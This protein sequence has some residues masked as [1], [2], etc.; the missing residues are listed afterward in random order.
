MPK[1]KKNPKAQDLNAKGMSKPPGSQR[2]RT[3]ASRL[4][5]S[6]LILQIRVCKGLFADTTSG[7]NFLY[8]T[9]YAYKLCKI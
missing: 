8:C 6:N 1:I 7:I 2:K 3:G 5:I 4:K 9:L